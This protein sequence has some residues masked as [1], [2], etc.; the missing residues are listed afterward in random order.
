[1]PHSQAASSTACACSSD[2]AAKRLPR[3][4]PPK[5]TLLCLPTPPAPPAAV[6]RWWGTRS[7]IAGHR[8]L[9]QG[10]GVHLGARAGFRRR[11]VTAADDLDRCDEVLVQVVHELDHPAVEPAGPGDV[12]EHRQVLHRLA[13]PDPA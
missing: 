7:A 10:G 4:A 5:P 11:P 2:I 13:E 6:P 8:V 1:M 3:L 9:G 12:V